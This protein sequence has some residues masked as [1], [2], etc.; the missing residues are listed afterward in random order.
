ML[1]LP[2]AIISQELDTGRVEK[3]KSFM[4]DLGIHIEPARESAPLHGIGVANLSL[5]QIVNQMDSLSLAFS[6]YKQK[7]DEKIQELIRR[8]D[9]LELENQRLQN[10]IFLSPFTA[11]TP[12]FRIYSK[13]EGKRFFQKGNDAYFNKNYN[14]AVDYLSKAI[15]SELSGAVVGDAY[16]WI[17]NCYIQLHDEYLALEYLKKVIEYPLSEKLDDALFLAA[18][19][20]RKLGNRKMAMIFLK[21][22]INRYPDGQ[23]TKL[24]DLELKR[25]ETMD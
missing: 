21:R 16:Y 13:K 25:L 18:V 8:S 24:A 5:I 12:P 9:S 7:T 20:Y 4:Y 2:L 6:Q 22:L 11:L 17:G 14:V 3:K 23:L 19:T 1:A 10:Q 15:A